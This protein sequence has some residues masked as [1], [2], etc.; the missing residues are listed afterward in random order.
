MRVICLSLSVA[1]LAMPA[2]GANRPKITGIAHVD[3]YTTEPEPNK[4]LYVDVFGL[5]SGGPLEA[6]ETETFL[7]G[8]QFVGYSPAP[9]PKLADRMDHVAFLTDNCAALR[10]YLAANGVKVP[11]SLVRMKDGSPS[12]LVNDPEGHRIEFVERPRA[13]MPGRA[14]EAKP[15]PVSRHLIHVGFVVRDRAAEDRF[16]KAVLGFRLY[17]YGGMTAGRTDWV[18]MQVP[19]GTDWLEYM[20]NVKPNP[21]LGL[22]GVM[23]H[24]SLGVK[25]MREAQAKLEAHGWKPNGKE[26]AQM[27][28]DGKRQLNLFDPDSTRIELMEFIPAEKPCCSEFQGPHPTE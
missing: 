5:A 3:F 6:G 26:H 16:Y 21:G 11:A 10:T 4:H 7:I 9:D 24:I 17:W 2:Q 8:R 20:L 22:N 23:N 12:F 18:A 25:D 15:D 13:S 1:L 27:G 28:R 14:P 19:D